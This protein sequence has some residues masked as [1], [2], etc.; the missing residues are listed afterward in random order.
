LKPPW[1]LPD[2]AS[3]RSTKE[4]LTNADFKLDSLLLLH[5]S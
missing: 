5:H 2:L 4:R 3:D 1:L